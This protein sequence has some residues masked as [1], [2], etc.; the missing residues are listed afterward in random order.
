MDGL[1]SHKTQHHRCR[2]DGADEDLSPGLV[3][4]WIVIAIVILFALFPQLFT[5]FNPV[6]GVP[7]E[8]LKAPSALHILGTGLARPRPLRPHRLWR[9]AFAHRRLR[10]GRGR[11]RRRHRARRPCRL[12]RRARRGSDH[13]ARRR[14]AVDPG[15]LADALDHHP[16]RLRHGERGDRRRHHLG[17]RFRPAFPLRSGA[18]P[19]LRLCRGGLRL[20]RHL[21]C[22]AVAARAAQLAGLGAG[23]RRAAVRQR[24]PRHLHPRLPRLRRPPPTPGMGPAD[25][26]GPQLHLDRLVADHRARHRRRA[27]GARGQPHQPLAREAADDHAPAL[28]RKPLRRLSRGRPDRPRHPRGELCHRAR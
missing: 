18:G 15:P 2:A 12:D 1:V 21:L 22:R 5:S 11:P 25:R 23:L 13:A 3:I 14:A 20:G 28:G 17:R 24:H 16:A 19:A 4:A 27:G 8:K 9:G 7:A 6:Q 10:R 26:R